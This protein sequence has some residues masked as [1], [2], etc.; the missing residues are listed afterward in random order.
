MSTADTPV[1][2]GYKTQWLAVRSSDPSTV[3]RALNPRSVASHSWSAGLK[4]CDDSHWFVSPS[5]DGWTLVVGELPETDHS[6]FPKLLETMSRE[7]GDTYYYGTHRVVDYHGWAKAQ[8]GRIVR[9]FEYLGESGEYLSD[10]GERLPEEVSLG[11]GTADDAFPDEETV[12]ALAAATSVATITL[13]K[14]KG[15]EG[16]GWL[17]E[18]RP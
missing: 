7:V 1:P 12:M 14:R 4:S 2:F 3:I 5:V 13:G 16:P 17:V 9:R 8:S 10:L 15:P 6:D 11:V 18:L